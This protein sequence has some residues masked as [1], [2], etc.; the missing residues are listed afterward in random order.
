MRKLNKAAAVLMCVALAAA[1]IMPL[2]ASAT[3]F[4]HK[5]TEGAV[6]DTNTTTAVTADDVA[7]DVA[8]DAADDAEETAG[9]EAADSDITMSVKKAP[10]GTYGKT[11]SVSFTVKSS[12]YKITG[13]TP[14]I[15]EAFP[16]ETAGD[17]YK[18]VS[19]KGTKKLQCTYEFT[20][21]QDVA[22]GYQSVAFVVSYIKN[23][24]TC[25][26]TKILNVKLTGKEE[27]EPAQ[28]DIAP[29]STPRLMVTGYDT[30]ISTISPNSTF[31]LTLH[32]KNT[33]KKA[34]S[35]VKL[36][37]ATAEG[38]FLP[39]SGASTAYI[40]S[41]GAGKTE[42]VT[43]EMKAASG[44]LNKPYQITVTSDY[45]DA[46]ANPYSAEDSVSIPV[47]L[48]DRIS[49][50][51]IMPPDMLTIGGSGEVSFTI[52]NLGGTTLSNV[53]VKCEGEDFT[54]EE[55][56]V[57]NIVSGGTSYASV[58]LYGSQVTTGDGTCK[59]I[60]TYENT[61]GETKTIEEETY[62]YVMEET[63]EDVAAMDSEY[64]D[65]E[66][67][68]SKSWIPIVIVVVI[69]GCAIVIFTKRKKRK[70]AMEEEEL[71]DD[72]VL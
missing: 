69:V 17:A 13:V 4:C 19:S 14:V 48:E 56:F 59:I 1:N 7:D 71:M 30:D 54:C 60:L 25:T 3:G 12:D 20:V 18:T 15:D 68:S 63:I 66:K 50:T 72:D 16:F 8:D 65:T 44:L 57:G 24:E 39:V 64:I 43:F 58:I 52:N 21:R 42:D 55:S 70:L 31:T 37:L 6:V 28:E 49:L 2:Q 11:C 9:V 47:V 46:D 23:K 51:E 35:N 45:E 62:V 34:I 10:S 5:Q 29:T 36:T 26:V 27:T 33:S 38:E 40:E 61:E 67:K 22:T 53:S 32:M 41:I